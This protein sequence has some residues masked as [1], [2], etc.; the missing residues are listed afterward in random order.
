MNATNVF[1]DIL[2][3]AITQTECDN[4]DGL[5]TD[6]WIRVYDISQKQ[7]LSPLIYQQIFSNPSFLERDPEFQNFWKMDTIDQAGNQVR[8]SILFLMLSDKMRQN[9]LTPLVVKGIVCRNLYPN[10]DLRTSN[11][12]D[13]F[14]PREQFQKMD[15]FLRN[16]GF[17]RDELIEGKDYQEVPYKN[18]S[19]GLYLEL[20]MNLFAQESGAYGHFNELF[21]DA[22]DTCIETEIQGSKVLTLN[23]REHFLYLVCH[24]LKHFLHSGFGIRQA[25]DMIYFAKNYHDQFD[26]EEIRSVMREYHMEAFAMNVLDIGVCYLGISWEEMGLTK[27]SDIDIDCTALL[28]DMLD[29]GIFG[30]NDMNR[31]HSANITLNAA[32]HEKASAASGIVASLFPDKEYMKTNYDYARKYPFLLPAAYIQRILKYLLKRKKT[33]QNTGEKSSTQIGM[34]RV[35]LLEKYKIVDK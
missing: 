4:L 5:D 23:V 19:N 16:E 18:L 13:L 20:H 1:L 35:K 14:I 33:G 22:F 28:D 2:K 31:V 27:P 21:A 11:D 34:E 15:E 17:M 24:S 25:C 30:Q 26:W 32:E 10:P 6:V 29:G 3:S 8:K 9:G 12:E 7:Q